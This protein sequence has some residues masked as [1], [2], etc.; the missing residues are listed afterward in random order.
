VQE[1]GK[2]TGLVEAARREIPP[3]LLFQNPTI[4]TPASAEPRTRSGAK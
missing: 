1:G 3:A 4:V 2:L